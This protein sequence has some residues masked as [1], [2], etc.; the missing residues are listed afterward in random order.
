MISQ[1]NI[2]LLSLLLLIQLIH[3]ASALAATDNNIHINLDKYLNNEGASGYGSNFDG[4]GTYFR[5]PTLSSNTVSMGTI[6]FKLSTNDGYDN[7]VCLGQTITVPNTNFGAI[8]LLGSVS[9]GPITTNINII[10]QDGTQSTTVLNIPD[11]QIQHAQQIERFDIL[12]CRLS[13]GVVATLASIPLLVDPAKPVSHLILPYTSQVGW[14]Q[15]ALHIFGITAVP[16]SSS[17]VKIISAKGKRRWWENS[18]RRQYQ[19]VAVKIHNTSPNWVSDL[20]VFIEGSL[21]K[22]KYH[23]NIKRLAPGHVVMVDVAILTIRKRTE[24]TQVLVEVVD[25]SGNRMAESATID[26][27][28]IGLEDYDT[29]LE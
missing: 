20:S 5:C 19:M 7:A 26:N 15:P 22:T 4:A 14:F 21:L 27:V 6:D 9:H 12:P 25:S 8:Y 13:N 3:H 24:L 10:Y 11:W 2:L 17:A 28:E 23:G 18:T 16:A 29:S 1:D